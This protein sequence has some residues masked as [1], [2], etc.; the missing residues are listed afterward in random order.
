MSGEALQHEASES[1]ASLGRCCAVPASSAATVWRWWTT[2]AALDWKPFADRVARLA[3]G[4]TQ[5]EWDGGSRCLAVENSARFIE[6][7]FAAPWG[8]GVIAP[9]NHRLSLTE[10]VEILADCG[11]KI[12]I[13]DRTHAHAVEELAARVALR[14]SC[15]P[16][17]S[18]RIGRAGPAMRT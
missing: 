10:I 13:V 15:W 8:G 17:R 12:L 18:L 4:L 2:S 14:I 1:A 7:Y 11:A 5:S 6:A 16:R 9:I 3:A